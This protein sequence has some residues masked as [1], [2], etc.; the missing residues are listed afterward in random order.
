[1]YMYMY[2]YSCFDTCI[3]VHVQYVNYTCTIQ[4]MHMYMY[5][6]CTTV[7]NMYAVHVYVAT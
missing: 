4:Y 3:R 7:H 1:M 2:M 6:T 5:Y